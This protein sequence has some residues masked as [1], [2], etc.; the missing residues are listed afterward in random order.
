MPIRECRVTFTDLKDGADH[1]VTVLAETTMAAA[2]IGLKRIREQ[3]FV[4]AD[5]AD[6]VRI[7]LVTVT[8]HKISLAKVRQWITAAAGRSPREASLKSRARDA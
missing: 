7:E 3:S 8:Q 1:T 6:P 4:E 5:F 2:A